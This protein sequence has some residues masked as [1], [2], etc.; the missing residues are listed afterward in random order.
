MS[1]LKFSILPLQ[2]KALT[3]FVKR[4]S[5]IENE[6]KEPQ[7]H[8]IPPLDTTGLTFFFGD[9][10]RNVYNGKNEPLQKRA[11]VLGITTKGG[12]S[13]VHQGTVKQ[14]FIEFTPTGFYRLFHKEGS[15]FTNHPPADFSTIGAQILEKELENCTRDIKSIQEVFETYLLSMIPTALPEIPLIDEVVKLMQTDVVGKRSIEDICEKVGVHQKNLFRLFKK[16]I[17]ISPK[18]YYRT[19]QWNTIMKIINQNEEKSL[20]KLALE[21]G[22]Y[23]HPSFTKEF[24][25]FMQISPSEFIN[26]DVS[27]TEMVLKYNS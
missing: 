21:C 14:I 7:L 23:D 3:P 15:N 17:G 1:N 2:E 26:G 9:L 4:M 16:V 20:T 8:P 5:Y 27:L 19:L 10:M 13:I 12:V 22:F 25:K 11:Y 18:K 6:T 24:K